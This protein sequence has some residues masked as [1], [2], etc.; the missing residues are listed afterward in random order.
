VPCNI[1]VIQLP[2]KGIRIYDILSAFGHQYPRV[3]IKDN[4][5]HLQCN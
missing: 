4:H 3:D 1:D 2:L 5:D